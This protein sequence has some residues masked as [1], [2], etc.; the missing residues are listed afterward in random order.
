[1]ENVAHGAVIQDHDFAEIGLHLTQ[2]LDIRPITKR[3]MLTVISPTKV[4]AFALEPINDRISI[5]LN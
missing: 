5:L 1:M 2:V 4:L 3:A